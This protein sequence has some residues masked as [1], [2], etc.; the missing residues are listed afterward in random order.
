[1]SNQKKIWSVIQYQNLPYIIVGC[2][3]TSAHIVTWNHAHDKPTIKQFM[4]NSVFGETIEIKFEE[5]EKCNLLFEY[6]K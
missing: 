2:S 5:L 1:M 6:R 4:M 3:N